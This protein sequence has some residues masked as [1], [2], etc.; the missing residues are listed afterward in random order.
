MLK[1]NEIEYHIEESGQISHADYLILQK[2]AQEA[3][4]NKIIEQKEAME[5]EEIE[6]LLK[7]HQSCSN[8][9]ANSQRYLDLY[10]MGNLNKQRRDRTS[11]EIE[12]ERYKNELTFKP[13]T[14]KSSNDKFQPVAKDIDKAIYRMYQGRKMRDK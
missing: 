12:L 10:A 2:K 3:K 14:I 6:T 8:N 5:E 4:L 13:N 7:Q 9:S 1:N 11:D